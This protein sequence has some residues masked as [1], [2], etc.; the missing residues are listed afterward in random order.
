MKGVP[1]GRRS[2][3]LQR[4]RIL[5]FEDRI[6]D[7]S[8]RL[9]GLEVRRLFF[10]EVESATVHRRKGVVDLVA[11]VVLT[12]LFLTIALL[13]AR[14]APPVAVLF[15]AIALATGALTALALVYP[16][17]RLVVY[18]P[19]QKIEIPLSRSAARRDRTLAR[20]VRTIGRYQDGHASP[21]TASAP[22][23]PAPEPPPAVSP[24]PS[25]NRV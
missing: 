3:T 24:R 5:L 25:P 2:G 1:I 7:V 16:Q 17:H 23:P 21:R 18:A 9:D 6:E 4:F 11:G 19:D 15:A 14:P 8:I 20:L 22:E 10:D 12:G 13:S